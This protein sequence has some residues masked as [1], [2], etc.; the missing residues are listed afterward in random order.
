VAVGV[1]TLLGRRLSPPGDKKPAHEVL[2]ELARMTELTQKV[3]AGQATAE[4][5]QELERL[6]ARPLG[7]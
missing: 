6:V 7:R 3:R 5:R 4:E 1:G 2:R